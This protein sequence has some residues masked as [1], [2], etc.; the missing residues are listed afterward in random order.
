MSHRIHRHIPLAN[1]PLLAFVESNLHSGAVAS[2]PPRSVSYMTDSRTRRTWVAT[3]GTLRQAASAAPAKLARRRVRRVSSGALEQVANSALGHARTGWS[4]D[5]RRQ[6]EHGLQALSNP[7][8]VRAASRE[9]RPGDGGAEGQAQVPGHGRR[10]R[11]WVTSSVV[12]GFV[13]IAMAAGC[14]ATVGR[15]SSIGWGSGRA[16]SWRW[17]QGEVGGV[18]PWWSAVLST[19]LMSCPEKRSVILDSKW[20]DDGRRCSNSCC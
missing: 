12:V 2:V 8:C 1:Q 14:F 13:R 20:L 10:A 3:E 18:A 5:R 16:K 9:Q 4:R 11:W 7:K 19:L 15:R 6:L 17:S